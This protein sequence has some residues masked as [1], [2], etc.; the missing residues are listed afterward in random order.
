MTDPTTPAPAWTRN[1]SPSLRR[2]LARIL[3]PLVV[4]AAVLAGAG[5][6][7]AKSCGDVIDEGYAPRDGRGVRVKCTRGAKR[8]RFDLG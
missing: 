5:P 3:V 1:Q 6:A 4:A 2:V 7:T 8:I